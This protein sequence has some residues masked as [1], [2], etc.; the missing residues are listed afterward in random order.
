MENDSW[1]NR[2]FIRNICFLLSFFWEKEGTFCAV[3]Q[4][5][6]FLSKLHYWF[7]NFFFFFAKTN[8]QF[9]FPH[10]WHEEISNSLTGWPLHTVKFR[11]CLLMLSSRVVFAPRGGSCQAGLCPSGCVQPWAV[12]SGDL[13]FPPLWASWHCSSGQGNEEKETDVMWEDRKLG[14]SLWLGLH[15]PRL[16]SVFSE[17]RASRTWLLWVLQF[18]LF[19]ELLHRIFP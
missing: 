6:H 1:Q 16:C 15:W 14:V 18:S 19:P 10:T 17:D 9:V 13:C 2:N 5:K 7:F 12:H 4:W 11:S 3:C 8:F